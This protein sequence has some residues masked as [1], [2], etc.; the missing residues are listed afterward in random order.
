MQHKMDKIR[1]LYEVGIEMDFIEFHFVGDA[2][3]FTSYPS[4]NITKIYLV[5]ENGEYQY[6]PYDIHKSKL[7]SWPLNY[8]VPIQLDFCPLITP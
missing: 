1:D 3:A 4:C 2:R 5:Y 6:Y 7:P 8:L